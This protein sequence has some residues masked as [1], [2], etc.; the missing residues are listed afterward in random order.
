MFCPSCGASNRA[1]A[2]F[3][4]DCGGPLAEARGREARKVVTALFADIVGSTSL[5]ERLDPEDF[6]RLVGDGVKG[7]VEEVEQ[8]GGTV[9]DLA[10]DGALALFGA[11]T[12]HED[13]PERAVLAGLR[14]VERIRAY[15]REVAGRYEADPIEVRVG[16]ETG[17]VVLGTT[18]GGGRVEYGAMGD[19]L[20]TAARLQSHAE[21]G[22]V[23]V[24]E[25]TRHVI[26]PLF[27]W[28]EA[29]VLE[30]KGKA[31]PV[32][33]FEALRPREDRPLDAGPSGA[34]PLV[35]REDEL[36]V[37]AELIRG[38]QA[39]DGGVL[40]VGGEAGHGKSRLLGE[41]RGLASADAL[42]LETRCLSYGEAIPYAPFSGLLRAWLRS[43]GPAPGEPESA[44]L[45]ARLDA[46]LGDAAAELGPPL[47]SLLGG[48]RDA[49]ERATLET[50]TP[51]LL[52]HRIFEGIAGVLRRL[53]DERPLV[54]SIDD[55]H[56]ADPS[57]MQL[58]E[59]LLPLVTDAAILFV[60]AG[61]PEG[62]GPFEC[63]R[64]TAQ[65]QVPACT[66][67]IALAAL[68]SEADGKLIA[69]MVGGG[70]LPRAVER[71]IRAQAE[72]NPLY[73]EQLVRSLIDARALVRETGGWRFDHDV[74]VEI[75]DTL[76]KLVLSRID[77]LDAPTHDV[78]AAASV[79]GRRFELP[80]LE[81]L[82]GRN[83]SLEAA[84][85]DL[86]GLELIV[87]VGP[88]AQPEYR[89][90]H[91]L[92]RDAVYNSLLKQRRQE[93]HRVAAE[94]L[95]SAL[96]EES[97][98]RDGVLAH[99]RSAAGDHS[100]ALDH[101]SRAAQAAM[102]VYA[103]DEAAE[104]LSGALAA[105]EALGMGL[106]DE[107]IR[108]L[109][110]E[111]AAMFAEIGR[112]AESVRDLTKLVEAAQEA[113][114]RGLEAEAHH[115]L[116]SLQ[117]MRGSWETAVRECRLAAEM[118][119]EIGDLELEV[120]SLGRLS[121]NSSND[122]RLDVALEMAERAISIAEGSEDEDIVA[123]ALDCLKLAAL[124][125]GDLTALE[126]ATARLAELHGGGWAP[127][128]MRG[129]ADLW[130]LQWAIL[131][132]AF[133]PLAQCDWE[134]AT[135][136]VEQALD[137][138]RR[139]GTHGHAALFFDAAGW[140]E[141]SRGDYGRAIAVGEEGV[142]SAIRGRSDEWTAWTNATLGW[143][144]LDLQAPVAAAARLEAGLEAAERAG[145]RAQVIRCL[146]LLAQAEQLRGAEERALE[147]A[148]RAEALLDEISAPPRTVWLFGSHVYLALAR[149][150]LASGD[151]KAALGLALPVGYAAE[152]DGWV[153]SATGALL[154]R[155]QAAA[156]AG[157]RSEA[158]EL[159]SRAL[160]QAHAAALPLL[161]WESHA[162]LARLRAD[163]DA[164][165]AGEHGASARAIADRLASTLDD[166][167]LRRGLVDAVA[168]H[169]SGVGA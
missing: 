135:A 77:R 139:A 136:R 156:D 168:A 160:H 119:R 1:G 95:A 101:H 68:G 7:I 62:E 75:P 121:I 12:A 31:Q 112:A 131:E 107:H 70:A 79:L 25:R 85:E 8:F 63:L 54:V 35:G 109:A 3:C 61:R 169:V 162:A 29:R 154:I 57:S 14:I 39:G 34:A 19:A 80:V 65:A 133:V 18:G 44:A 124:Y 2:R 151:R 40:L 113:G 13:D 21:P 167:A 22:T 164:A 72:G 123:T 96:P 100:E 84:L 90:K 148:R 36:D 146:G 125:L 166:E 118:A 157:H 59:R 158:L 130:Y 37:G 74:T 137:A 38:L 47:A 145:A 30:L 33:A 120:R 122:L 64:T 111:R 103:T 117:R 15:A 48:A 69:G 81:A 105:G 92:I 43:N 134:A 128:T 46:L 51:E 49:D 78:L 142:Q 67:E 53:A 66:T 143:T 20:N 16:I 147:L 76:E 99:H 27:D 140:L 138:N 94:T 11:P 114:D 55:L 165:A 71:R 88:A 149:V 24:G 87:A 129:D 106:E 144:L 42:W 126:E 127:Q 41:F 89:F 10:G 4:N 83:E 115:M 28:G 23:L 132:S 91:P 9:K 56:W 58:A 52:Q 73:L 155:G 152:R 141:R 26:E 93:L 116:G 97:A 161:E 108:R 86:L 60:L 32:T 82:A 17:L 159:L 45:H 110:L 163:D 50:L 98:G 104:H 150:R 102:R 6:R 153:E 5:G